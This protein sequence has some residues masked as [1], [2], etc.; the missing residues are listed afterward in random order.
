MLERDVEKKLTDLTRQA[1]GKSY[2]WV[3]PGNRG[4]PDRILILP[5]GRIYFVELKTDSGRLTA[6]Q[7]RQ[8]K[9][10]KELGANVRTLYGMG[11]IEAF[12]REV[13]RDEVHTA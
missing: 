2:K 9:R 12:A 11:E 5:G 7:I 8:Q 10:L 6:I 1:G 4:V 3:A 13:M